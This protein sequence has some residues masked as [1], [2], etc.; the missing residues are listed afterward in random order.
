MFLLRTILNILVRNA[1]PREHMCFSYLI[2]SLSGP[3]ELFIFALFNCLLGVRSGEC[4][5]VFLYVF[6][7]P[8]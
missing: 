7:F 4:D 6:V 8:C 5:V 1:N 3:C 2:F